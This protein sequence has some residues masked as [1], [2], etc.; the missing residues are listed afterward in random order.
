MLWRKNNRPLSVASVSVRKIASKLCLFCLVVLALPAGAQETRFF[1]LGTGPVDGAYFPIGG[2]IANAISKPPGARECEKGGS[3]GVPGLVAVAQST[4][5]SVANVEAIFK[6]RLDAAIVQADIA[7]WAYNGSGA[8]AGKGAYTNLRGVAVL[9]PD[10]V[11]VAI[12]KGAKIKAIADLKGKRVAL[13]EQ[14]SGTLVTA[15]TILRAHN[16]KDGDLKAHYLKPGASADK[17]A[18]GELDALFVVDGA[19]SAIVDDLAGRGLIELLGFPATE[20]EKL[21]KASPFFIKGEL[22]PKTYAGLDTALPVVQV[23]VVLLVGSEVP[24]ALVYGITKALWH[25]STLKLLAGGHPNGRLIKPE[26]AIEGLAIQL[27]AGAA[28]YYFDAGLI[29]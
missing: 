10:T 26:K 24:E 3:C 2:L 12:R 15:R 21:R 20:A 14:G 5:G 8:F 9:Y 13:G 27:H 28:S 16:L 1:R 22:A 17:L 23:G 4:S 6:K 7:Y 19:P 29:K 25:E 18:A 11:H